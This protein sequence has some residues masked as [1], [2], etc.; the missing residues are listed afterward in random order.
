MAA[1][2]HEHVRHVGHD[3]HDPTPPVRNGH[4]KILHQPADFRVGHLDHHRH[5]RAGRLAVLPIAQY[6][7]IAPPTVL[8]TATYPGASAETLAKTV[9]APIE[10]QLNGVENMLYF[11]SSATANGTVTITATFEVGT[12]VDMAVN[13]NNRVKAAEP[14]LPTRCAQRR[15]RPEAFQRHPEGR[16]AESE[17]GVQHAVPVQ[18]RQPEHRR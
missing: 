7:Q 12:N 9:A 1:C 14:R 8:I 11:N 2:C 6:P 10:E 16:C 3:G 15:D 18:L 13:V 5:C 17:G 4:V